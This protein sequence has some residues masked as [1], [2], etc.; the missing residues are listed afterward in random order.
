[1]ALVT[2][3]QISNYY[4]QFGD[5]EVA[6]N[7]EVIRATGLQT[8]NNLVKCKGGYWPCFVYSSSMR[9]AKIVASVK[10]DFHKKLQEA[11]NLVSLQ[12]SFMQAEK[13]SPLILHISAKLTGTAKYGEEASNLSLLTLTYTQRPSDDLIITLGRLLES[14]LNSQKRKEERVIITDQ[15]LRKM[16]LK[17]NNIIVA[18]DNIPRKA[19]LR[20][21]SFSGAKLIIAGLA[22]FLVDK[23]I[24][25]KLE[26]EETDETFTLMGKVLRFEPIEN[27]KDIAS[28]A[29]QFDENLIPIEFKLFFNDFL[30]RQR[31]Q[32]EN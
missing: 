22:K 29:V 32:K 12:L 11:N 25:I 3:Q 13:S 24:L 2:G 14:N 10:E 6:F 17:S 9:Q 28:I 16:G 8:R 19:L 4:Q 15:V 1:M 18:I 20:D 27:R 30:T 7:K 26:V 21:L 31:P 5:V 23:A